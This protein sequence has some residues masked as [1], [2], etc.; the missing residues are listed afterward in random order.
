MKLSHL[1]LA[2]VGGVGVF[3]LARK[4]SAGRR[5][6]P[7]IPNR[8][9]ISP[10][11]ASRENNRSHGGADVGAL[12]GDPIVAISDGVVLH[13]VSGFSLGTGL[14]AVAIAHED[15]DY[16][17]CEIKVEVQAGQHVKAGERIGVTAKNGDG[18]SMLHLEVWETGTAPKGFV[19]WFTNQPRPKGMLDASS[20][21][22]SIQSLPELKA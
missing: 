18:R 2:T 16:L 11:G 22:A 1:F 5:V 19:P 14:Q 10:F 21:L 13:P 12:P 8:G 3:L 6:W 4:V 9:V 20:K 7:V 15:A 17:Y